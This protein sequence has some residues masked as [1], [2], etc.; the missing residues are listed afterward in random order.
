MAQPS[1]TVSLLFSDIEGSTRLLAELGEER[2]AAALDQH[3]MLLRAAFARHDGYEVDGEGDA[4][5]VAFASASQAVAAAGEAQRALAEHDWPDGQALRV[6]MGVHTGEPLLAPPKYVGMDVH[7]AAR[8]MAAAHGGQVLVSAATAALLDSSSSEPQSPVLRDLGEHRFKDLAV[9]ERVFQ[10]GE[11]EFPQIRSLHRSNLPVPATAFLGRERELAEVV[12]LLSREDVRLV[13]LTGPGGTGKTRLAL[14]AAAEVSGSFPDGVWWVPLS[15]LRDPAL[16]LPA[17]AQVLDAKEQ[18]GRDL[19][20]TFRERLAGKRPLLLLDNAEHLLPDLASELARLRAAVPTLVLLVTSRERLQLGG[21]EVWPVPALAEQE[22]VELFLARTRSLGAGVVEGPVVTELCARLDNLPLALEL[23][24]ARTV[25]FSPEQLLERLG[26]RLDLLKGGRDADPRQQTLRATIDWSYQLLDEE[27]Q[28]VFGALS[29]FPGGCTYDAAEQVAGGSLDSLQSLLDKSLLRRRETG[30]ENRYWLLGSIGDFAA[31]RLAES[32]RRDELLG[33][34][35][36]WLA[37]LSDEHGGAVRMYESRARAALR[38]EQP[39]VL[40]AL[41]WAVAHGRAD[42]AQRLLLG[43]WFLWVTSGFASEGSGWAERIVELPSEPTERYGDALLTAGEF[44]RFRGDPERALELKQQGLEILERLSPA[45]SLLAAAHTDIAD[46]LL[47]LGRLDET[48]A[49]ARKGLALRR[50]IGRSYGTAHALVTLAEVER[51]RGEPEQ[52]LETYRESVT[53]LETEGEY[54]RLEAAAGL[55]GIGGVARALGR[56][57]M[58]RASLVEAFTRARESED[59]YLVAE[60]VGELGLLRLDEGAPE[61]AARL[62]CR[63]AVVFRDVGLSPRRSDELDA[64][65]MRAHELL[66]EAQFAA[67]EAA[68]GGLTLDDLDHLIDYGSSQ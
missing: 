20:G 11:G 50:E 19:L 61:A 55:V 6:R 18:P 9:A 46:V 52:A 60:V 27:E 53:L 43:N 59:M 63:A 51:A 66:G 39:N 40:Q 28:R 65:L 8:I 23:A 24:A 12:G 35:L 30:A 47:R 44:P 13:T 15:P 31:E 29:V 36:D 4:F 21:E 33:N 42:A 48:E 34:L 62:F 14:Q 32:G 58:A 49:S 56:R 3:R 16:L 37:Q 1:G 64:G 7:R 26:Q 10:L 5:F 54:G 67:A 68:A 41:E 25:V 2:Y 22:G 57:D 17:V 38:D 45:S